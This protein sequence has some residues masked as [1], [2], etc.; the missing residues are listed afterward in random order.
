MKFQFVKQYRS[1]FPVWRMCSLL[2]ISRSG[3][4]RWLRRKK[5]KR[6]LETDKLGNMVREIFNKCSGCYGSPR[7]TAELH[8]MGYKFSENRVAKIMK[9]MGLSA[10]IKP[11]FKVLTTNSDH[12]Y[13]ISPNVLNQDFHISKPNKAWVSDITYIRIAGGWCMGVPMCDS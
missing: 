5:S 6:A 13:P 2:D 4:H 3:F 8:D 11:K 7:I 9:N 1:S 12:N 10:Q